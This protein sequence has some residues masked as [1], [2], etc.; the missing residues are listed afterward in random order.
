MNEE[1]H[2]NFIFRNIIT[3]CFFHIES[4]NLTK[5]KSSKVYYNWFLFAF[6]TD[7]ET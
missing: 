4:A 3:N 7:W 6:T 1:F 5:F 2:Y